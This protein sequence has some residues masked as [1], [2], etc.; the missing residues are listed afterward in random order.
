MIQRLQL[1]LSRDSSALTMRLSQL[2]LFGFF[3]FAFFFRIGNSQSSMQDR[4][5]FLYEISCGP[6]FI[7]RYLARPGGPILLLLL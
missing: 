5:G 3:M 4:V 2:F 7:G 1:N 6:I